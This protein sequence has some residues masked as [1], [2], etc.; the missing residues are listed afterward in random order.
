M[1]ECQ[2][3]FGPLGLGLG[4]RDRL[5]VLLH[6]VLAG[7]RVVP[8]VIFEHLNS[9]KLIFYQMKVPDVVQPVTDPNTLPTFKKLLRGDVDLTSKNVSEVFGNKKTL[10]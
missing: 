9:I 8:A 2:H 3:L 10:F 7:H 1:K 5:V 6:L 4:E